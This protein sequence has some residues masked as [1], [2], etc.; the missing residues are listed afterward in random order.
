METCQNLSSL[1]YLCINELQLGNVSSEL[2]ITS[3]T[4]TTDVETQK[5]KG[6]EDC[7]HNS[8]GDRT[9]KQNKSAMQEL[10]H[11]FIKAIAPVA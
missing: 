9:R 4:Q 7:E 11:S 2:S 6:A 1:W 8:E 10:H 3:E 5:Q